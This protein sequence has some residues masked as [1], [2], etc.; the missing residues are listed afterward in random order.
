MNVAVKI[1]EKKA[2]GRLRKDKRNTNADVR[3]THD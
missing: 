2:L 3:A 1:L